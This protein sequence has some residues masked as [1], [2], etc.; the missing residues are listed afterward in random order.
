VR[1]QRPNHSK[2]HI[3]CNYFDVAESPLGNPQPPTLS[4]QATSDTFS[5]FIGPLPRSSTKTKMQPI[6]E[7]FPRVGT[8]ESKGGTKFTRKVMLLGKQHSQNSRPAETGRKKT[9]QTII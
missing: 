5:A 9:I 6:I 3:S 7:K 1:T 8:L 2:Y 4:R